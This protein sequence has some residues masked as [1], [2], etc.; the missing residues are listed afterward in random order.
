MLFGGSCGAA[1]GRP[2]P[3]APAVAAPAPAQL[4]DLLGDFGGDDAPAAPSAA[5]GATAGGAGLEDLLGGGTPVAMP[6][7]T[8]EDPLAALSGLALRDTTPTGATAAAIGSRDPFADLTSAPAA[9]SGHAVDL[10]SD[11]DMLSD[12]M[13]VVSTSADA[14]AHAPVDPLQSLLGASPADSAPALALDAA[15][16]APSYAVPPPLPVGPVPYRQNAGVP[17]WPSA[18]D[19]SGGSARCGEDSGA[20]A[21]APDA[22]KSQGKLAASA[23]KKKGDAFADLLDM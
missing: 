5:V 4:S 13:P 1:A 6:T 20:A 19:A 23:P 8:A 2:Q 7:G 10:A 9:A 3:P 17:G 11:L 15:P 12:P 16:V 14:S 21:G 18:P 22:A